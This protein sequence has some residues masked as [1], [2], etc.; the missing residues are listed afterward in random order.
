MPA[1]VAELEA[2]LLAWNHVYEDIR[3]HEALGYLT[4]NEFYA[5]WVA[6][7][8]PVAAAVSDMS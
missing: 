6:E 5:Q 1:S 2:K 3:P 8:A 4:P 7:R